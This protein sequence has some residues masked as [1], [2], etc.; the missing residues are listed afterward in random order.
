MANSN[1]M[2]TAAEKTPIVDLHFDEMKETIQYEMMKAKDVISKAAT[3]VEKTAK[4]NP[5]ATAGILVGVGALI[6]A[7]L[8]ALLWPRPTAN[9]VIM[10]ALRQ[11][12][13]STGK[14]LNS[15]WNSARRA[16]R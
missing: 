6:G 16:I 5:K 10:R 4:A 11:S 9:Q 8:F 14:T 13:N 15:A 7:G 3:Q 2:Q 1:G 12:A